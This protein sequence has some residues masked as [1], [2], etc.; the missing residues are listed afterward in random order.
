M[1][2]G[3]DALFY[4][5]T[6]ALFAVFILAVILPIYISKLIQSLKHSAWY[7][8]PIMQASAIPARRCIAHETLYQSG[9]KTIA[10]ITKI[11][12]IPLANASEAV[13]DNR[14][15][16]NHRIETPP[17]FKIWYK[18]NPPDDNNP[19]D[20]IHS[21]TLHRDPREFL[22][23]GDSLPIL[24]LV[25]NPPK[26]NEQSGHKTVMSMPYPLPL[27]DIETAED[28]IYIRNYYQ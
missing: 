13:K 2:S 24:Y 4:G 25:G 22:K 28:Y 15:A 27:D 6:S 26:N 23:P 21:I 10:T 16:E 17:T 18:F 19:D 8:P 12:Y 9:R 1:M 20:V 11:D 14:T 3:S 5:I 7:C